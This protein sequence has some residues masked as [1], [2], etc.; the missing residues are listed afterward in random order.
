[1]Y[2]GA[3]AAPLLA[4]A[5]AWNGIAVELSDAAVAFEAVITRL[6][7]EYWI[8]AASL[9]MAAS[10]QPILG[11]LN[12]TAEASTL[13]AGQAMA[14]AAA[15]Q[16]AFALTVP[17]AEVAANRTQ[18]EALL[19]GN[20]FGQNGPLIATVEARYGEMWV[21]DAA[22]MYQYAADSAVAGRLEPLDN[23]SEVTNPAGGADQAAAVGQAA[24]SAEQVA[25]SSVVSSGPEAVGGL[26]E[27]VPA[28]P[29]TDVWA[30]LHWLDSTEN[31]LW[32]GFDH[33]RATYWDYSVGQI[34]SGGGD[35]E[36]DEEVEID[37]GLAPPIPLDFSAS[38][39]AAEV[40]EVRM[41]AVLGSASAVGG[42]SVPAGWANSTPTSTAR[43][44]VD[45][46]YWAPPV[47]DESDEGIAPS[48]GMYADGGDARAG[49]LPRYG[50]KPR[51]MPKQGSF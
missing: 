1:M 40:G 46:T 2:V 23:P 42:L 27:P 44:V 24:A 14:S 18:L 37:L 20:I 33:N 35:E 32:G 51:V 50:V 31:P 8:S 6:S 47:E 3:G 5:A 4:A 26:A 38:E 10:A 11:W 15:Y 39:I 21:Q 29:I 19:A 9:S 7:S 49:T 28:P 48:P 36:R 34:G 45:G 12:S 22:A 16:R 25:L 30:F 43:A 17:P 13:A 41:T